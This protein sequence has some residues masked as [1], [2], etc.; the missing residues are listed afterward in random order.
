[1]KLSIPSVAALFLVGPMAHAETSIQ[2][3]LWE[4]TEKVTLDD[5]AGF[6]QDAE[7]LGNCRASY[8]ELDGDFSRGQFSISDQMEDGPAARLGNRP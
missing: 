2:A 4:K 3:G 8:L 5:K 7:V 6:F 1:M